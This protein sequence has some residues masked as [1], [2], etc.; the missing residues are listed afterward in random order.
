MC[1]PLSMDR[2]QMR[3]SVLAPA[4]RGAD[5]Y[6]GV[7]GGHNTSSWGGAVLFGSDD[8]LWHMWASEMTEHCG[9]GAWAQN[10]RIVHAV[11]TDPAGPYARKQVVWEVFSHEPEVVRGPNGEYVMFFTASLRSSRGS[12]TAV[13]KIILRATGQQGQ[14]TARR[15]PRR[16]AVALDADPSWMSY[17]MRP[18]GPWSDPVQIF[19]DTTAR[20]RTFHQPYSLTGRLSPYGGSGRDGGR[21][22]TWLPPRTGETQPHTLST[23]T[24]GRCGRTWDLRERRTRSCIATRTQTFTQCS[25]TCMDLTRPITGGLMLLAGMPSQGTARHGFTVAW[26]GDPPRRGAGGRRRV[27]RRGIV[28][29][30]AERASP[31]RVSRGRHDLSLGDSGTVWARQE[32]GEAAN[33]GDASF[34]LV[35]PVRSASRRLSN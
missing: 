14:E 1:L 9:I 17:A 5:G 12:A 28:P 13:A 8:G 35:Q 32:S 25:I 2:Q 30:H 24:R 6:R 19:K 10:S 4:T 3:N 34:T 11:S 21:D 22:A 29:L 15:A 20:T 16:S 26:P 27:Q 18:D 23:L 7:D 33:N 31:P